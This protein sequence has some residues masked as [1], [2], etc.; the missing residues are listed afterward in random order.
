MLQ[1]FVGNCIGEIYEN[2]ESPQ[3]CFVP[4]KLNPADLKTR[5]K[6]WKNQTKGQFG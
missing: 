5:G 4:G 3:S 6:V 2:S 1:T